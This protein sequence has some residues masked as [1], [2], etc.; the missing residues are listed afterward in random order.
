MANLNK[1]VLGR[2]S[3]SIGD[4]V[5]RERNGKNIVGLKPSSFNTPEDP[6]SVARRGKFKMAVDVAHAIYQDSKLKSLWKP[7]TPAGLSPFNYLV[8]KNYSSVSP[9]TPGNFILIVPAGGF[10]ITA[11]D[12]SK[13]NTQ[14]QVTVDA[15]GTNNNI[16]P[17]VETKI[18]MLSV[19]FNSNPSEEDTAPYAF[20]TL[21]S[22]IITLSLTGQL[23]FNSP[24]TGS[25]GLLFD[26]YQDHQLYLALVTMD[27]EE[28]IIH[29]SITLNG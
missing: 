21:P 28:K 29:N 1:Q 25:E 9:D 24:L 16:D 22:G 20:L 3:G 12:I 23:I 19:L 8:K 15:I 4:I 26:L 13:S 17:V 27:D 5:F 2:L 14:M 10:P 7:G 11:S 18:Q 6:A